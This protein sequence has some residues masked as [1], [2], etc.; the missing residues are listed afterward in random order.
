MKPLLFGTLTSAVTVVVYAGLLL[1]V[2]SSM[3]SQP[4]SMLGTKIPP[5]V[6]VNQPTK[7]SE[8]AAY[9]VEALNKLVSPVALYPDPL[10]AQVLPAST[11][12]VEVAQ[13]SRWVR[14]HRGLKAAELEGSLAVQPWAPSV[15]ALCAFPEV[16]ELMDSQNEWTTRLGDALLNKEQDVL[17]AIQRMRVQAYDAGA[18]QSNDKQILGVWEVGDRRIVSIRPQETELIYVPVYD[19][20]VVYA[21]PRNAGADWASDQVGFGFGVTVPVRFWDWDCDW[22]QGLIVFDPNRYR[23]WHRR[24]NWDAHDWERFDWG[25]TTLND[26]GATVDIAQVEIDNIDPN[27]RDWRHTDLKRFDW[28]RIDWRQVDFAKLE[29]GK[30]DW[31]DL[32]WEAAG[33]RERRLVQALKDFPAK[34]RDVLRG[35]LERAYRNQQYKDKLASVQ[36]ER[37]LGEKAPEIHAARWAHNP[38]HRRGVAYTG[39]AKELFAKSLFPGRR[40][41]VVAAKD[42]KQPGTTAQAAGTIVARSPETKSGT[43][44]KRR[45][46]VSSAQKYPETVRRTMRWSGAPPVYWIRPPQHYPSRRYATPIPQGQYRLQER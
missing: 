14:E 46:T 6:A 24:I 9:T 27:R 45:P 35:R 41:G 38:D 28:N 11:Y 15:K 37:L 19:P 5:A 7:K 12:P 31:E 18:L 42:P 3:D 16:L 36:R 40:E 25:A 4:R 2:T 34:E 33:I 21:R 43:A 39:Q 1:S 8:P 32:D 22:N 10:L 26:G 30:K 20:D 17:D 44:T 23:L 29:L 13:A